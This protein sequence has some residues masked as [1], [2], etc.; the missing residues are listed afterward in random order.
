MGGQLIR[1]TAVGLSPAGQGL[2]EHVARIN[3]PEG[4]AAGQL[5]LHSH[6]PVLLFS[7]LQCARAF[8]RSANRNVRQQFLVRSRRDYLINRANAVVFVI[9]NKRPLSAHGC[10]NM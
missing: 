7:L 5:I 10:N 9:R 1:R 2:G 4:G 6:W 8:G 3:H